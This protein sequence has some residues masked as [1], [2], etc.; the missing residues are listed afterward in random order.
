MWWEEVILQLGC[1]KKIIIWD[2]R[3]ERNRYILGLNLDLRSPVNEVE[4]GLL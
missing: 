3:D 4:E 2:D 1:N